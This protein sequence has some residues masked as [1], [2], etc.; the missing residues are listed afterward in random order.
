MDPSKNNYV[1]MDNSNNASNQSISI[2]SLGSISEVFSA[3]DKGHIYDASDASFTMTQSYKSLTSYGQSRTG[4][5][6]YKKTAFLQPA[7]NP[8]LGRI[9]DTS[10]K[11]L[12]TETT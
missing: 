6:S 3:N 5:E 4:S 12:P 8:R 10:V 11:I 7:I 9:G 1:K 2:K